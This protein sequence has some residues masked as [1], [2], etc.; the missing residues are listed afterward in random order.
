MKELKKEGAYFVSE[1]YDLPDDAYKDLIPEELMSQ[2]EVVLPAG[3]IKIQDKGVAKLNFGDTDR[4]IG[5]IFAKL[6][7]WT[8]E[9]CLNY[10]NSNNF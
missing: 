9:E 2:S 8:Y 4:F 10:Y 6:E 1:A 5:V 7:P 3:I